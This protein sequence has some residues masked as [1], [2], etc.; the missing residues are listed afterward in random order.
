M[1]CKPADLH[2]IEWCIPNTPA[3]RWLE[4]Q[5]YREVEYRRFHPGETQ[6][7]VKMVRDE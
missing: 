6:G 3:Q 2:P 7:W 4:A 1:S 5:G